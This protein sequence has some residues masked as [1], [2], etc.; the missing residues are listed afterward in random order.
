M[1]ATEKAVFAAGCFWGVQ[2]A[3]DKLPGVVSTR[4]GYTGGTTNNPTYEQVCTNTTGHA[5]AVEVT[6]DPAKTSFEKLLGAFF[7]CHDPTTRDRQGPDFGSQYR[8]AIF[9]TNENQKRQAES[10]KKLLDSTKAFA[11]PIVT[12]VT[13]AGP[14][15]EAEAYHQKYYIRHP[16]VCR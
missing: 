6:F 12:E 4:V 8:S 2:A 16:G 15:F 11:G 1:T 14:F 9:Y 13:K 7:A 10:M 5:E 3:F